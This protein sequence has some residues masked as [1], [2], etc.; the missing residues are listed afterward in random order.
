MATGIAIDQSDSR[1]SVLEGMTR[2]RFIKLA[3]A[4]IVV[5]FA[6][7]FAARAIFGVHDVGC[8]NST[9]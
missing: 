5:I 3:L 2:K 1:G 8:S 6:V 9:S 4:G 7:G